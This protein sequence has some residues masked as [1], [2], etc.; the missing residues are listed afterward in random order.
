MSYQLPSFPIVFV[1][2]PSETELEER[3]ERLVDRADRALMSG[4]V[5]QAEYDT[6]YLELNRAIKQVPLSREG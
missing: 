5:T 3:I 2:R 6:W 4:S 1:G